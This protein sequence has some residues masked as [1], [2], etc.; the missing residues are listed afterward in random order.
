MRTA[1]WILGLRADPQFMEA[2][3]V[4]I[5]GELHTDFSGILPASITQGLA[6]ILPVLCLLSGA[7]SH[8]LHIGIKDWL[9][10]QGSA[11]PM[12]SY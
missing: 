4:S 6:L 11:Q 5:V 1:I 12:P 2:G 3:M 10:V 7:T 8:L 9:R